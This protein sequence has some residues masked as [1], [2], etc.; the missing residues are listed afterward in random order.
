MCCLKTP[1]TGNEKMLGGGSM[2]LCDIPKK[3]VVVGAGPAG[4]EAARVAALR[5]HRVVVFEKENEVGGQNRFAAKAAGRQEIQGVT[6]WLIGQVEKLDIDLRLETAA[7][8]ETV[9]AENPDA[10][11]VATGSRPKENPCSGRLRAARCGQHLAG[12]ERGG[13][14]RPK[15]SFHRFERPPSWDRDR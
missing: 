13:G 12:P 9:L 10:V 7:T 15:G 8:A 11:V 5:K 2:T 6:R 14:G 3:V 4:L 1:V